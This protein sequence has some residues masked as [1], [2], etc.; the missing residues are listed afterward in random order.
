LGS[1]IGWPQKGQWKVKWVSRGRRV[2][3]AGFCGPCLYWCI[4]V[5][6]VEGACVRNCRRLGLCKVGIF[7]L[8]VGDECVGGRGSLVTGW[9]RMEG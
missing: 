6:V 9:R 1:W 7:S 5:V 2:E 3:P 8:S 4:F